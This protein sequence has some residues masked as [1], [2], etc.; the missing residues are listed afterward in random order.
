MDWQS[1]GFNC[2]AVSLPSGYPGTGLHVPVF[3]DSEIAGLYSI[4]IS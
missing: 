2:A 4:R 3:M 1:A